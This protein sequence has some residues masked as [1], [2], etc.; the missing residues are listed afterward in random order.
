MTPDYIQ[1][2]E[3]FMSKYKLTEVT[4]EEIGVLIGRMTVYF[5]RY[6]LKLVEA[7]KALALVSRDIYGQSDATTAKAITAS[8][9]EILAAATPE[10]FNYNEAKAHVENLEQY[11]QSMKAV[12]RGAMFEYA[13]S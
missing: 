10:A 9:A 6:N 7:R 13:A 11:I 12:Q 5:S 8:K 2:Y 1:E 4:G 3:D